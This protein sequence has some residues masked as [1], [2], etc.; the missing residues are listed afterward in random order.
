MSTVI[1]INWTEQARAASED[2]NAKNTWGT[3]RGAFTVGNRIS[4]VLWGVKGEI[5]ALGVLVLR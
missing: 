3:Q 4:W 5:L 2:A 1:I